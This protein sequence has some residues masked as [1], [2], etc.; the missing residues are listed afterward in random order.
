[1]TTPLNIEVMNAAVRNELIENWIDPED[2]KYL[3]EA[4]KSINDPSHC[5]EKGFDITKPTNKQ[6][7]ASVMGDEDGPTNIET[8]IENLQKL[9]DK[10]YTHVDYDDWNYDDLI[11][12]KWVPETE[13]ECAERIAPRIMDEIHMLKCAER[14]REKKLAKLEK[15]K[16]EV[17]K[18]EEE[19]GTN[20]YSL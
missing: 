16:N 3:D 19:L 10:G 11:A 4:I 15:L 14:T 9:K 18:L 8:V 12:M 17:A 1:M 7:G 2:V 20:E 6:I 5:Y 13:A